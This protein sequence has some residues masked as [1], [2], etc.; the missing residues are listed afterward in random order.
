MSDSSDGF[1]ALLQG[2]PRFVVILEEKIV[3]GILLN[4]QF[5]DSGVEFLPKFFDV[6]SFAGRDEHTFMF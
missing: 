2:F 3:V 5:A 4:V 1:K 6:G